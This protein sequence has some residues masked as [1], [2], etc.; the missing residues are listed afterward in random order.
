MSRT[1]HAAAATEAAPAA[2]QAM[3]RFRHVGARSSYH[4]TLMVSAPLQGTQQYRSR[5]RSASTSSPHQPDLHRQP[6]GTRL[7][8]APDSRDVRMDLRGRRWRLTAVNGRNRGSRAS[9]VPWARRS[10]ALP[11]ACRPAYEIMEWPSDFHDPLA[12]RKRDGVAGQPR[13]PRA[14]SRNSCTRGRK[15]RRRR[16]IR[17]GTLD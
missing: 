2:R 13:G 8:P 14:R 11:A 10:G 12:R 7:G 4:V 15:F 9:R 16:G 17:A 3:A 5:C 6:L 1:T